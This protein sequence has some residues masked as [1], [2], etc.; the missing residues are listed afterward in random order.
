MRKSVNYSY[1]CMPCDNGVEPDPY[2]RAVVKSVQD[3]EIELNKPDSLEKLILPPDD[4][5]PNC[6][7][8]WCSYNKESFFF[9][10]FNGT[11]L[12]RG[13]QSYDVILNNSPK[14]ILMYAGYDFDADGKTDYLVLDKNKNY[15]SIRLS[16]SY[17]QTPSSFNNPNSV[18]FLDFNGDG[19]TDIMV[20]KDSNCKIYSINN[21]THQF[22]VIYDSGFPT[23]W[24]RFFLG[25]FNGDGKSDILSYTYSGDKTWRI[26]LSNGKGFDWPEIQD[27]PLV[28]KDPG[29]SDLDNNIYVVDLNSDG[30]SDILEMCRNYDN[31]TAAANYNYYIHR[32]NGIFEKESVIAGSSCATDNLSFYDRDGDGRVDLL[33]D[34]SPCMSE[35]NIPCRVIFFHRD[36]KKSLVHSITDGFGRKFSIS[37]TSLSKA[38][39]NYTPQTGLTFPLMNYNGALNAVTRTD[40]SYPGLET[41]S[42]TFS[43]TAAVVHRQG[44]GLLGFK[45]ILQTNLLTNTATE[46]LKG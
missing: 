14:D 2:E 31:N 3:S 38:G 24:H 39:T 23:K 29:A 18:D 6:C 43:Y 26:S 25:D 28:K 16:Y 8:A 21:I 36:E 10:T 35:E 7:Q 34:N 22:D 37:Y 44:K 20:I 19:G 27:L 17:V 45:K 42:N 40:Y 9:Y 1:C 30:K 15:N 13:S 41:V 33:D 32:G 4:P 11:T 12:V 46:W 5:D